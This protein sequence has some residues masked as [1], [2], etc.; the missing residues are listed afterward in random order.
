[1]HHASRSWSKYSHLSLAVNVVLASVSMVSA[2]NELNLRQSKHFHVFLRMLEI[3]FSMTK[4]S[5]FC[6][7]A[8]PRIHLDTRLFEPS[9]L[10]LRSAP[11]LWVSSLSKA[12]C[13][14]MVRSLSC[15]PCGLWLYSED[16]LYLVRLE[17]GPGTVLTPFII[18]IHHLHLVHSGK[19]YT[20]TVSQKLVR[21]QFV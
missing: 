9:Y 7:G 8:C 20:R 1:M 12:A 10:N 18:Y 6:G 21:N 14:H 4:F 17:L 11:G 16:T 15:G 2:R 13:C 19:S 5:N 3:A